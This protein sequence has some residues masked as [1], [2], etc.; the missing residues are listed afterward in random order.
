MRKLILQIQISVDGYIADENGNVDWLIWPWT[1]E[2]T[3]DP[4][5]RQYFYDLKDSIDTVL[6]SRKMAQEGF[7]NHWSQ[8]A[9]K[10]SNPQSVFAK[11][12]SEAKKIVF[13]RTLKKSEWDNAVLA[14]EDF[15]KEINTLKAQQG[16]DIIVYGGATFV[17]SLIDANLIDEFYLF[18]NPTSLG[19]GLSIFKDR[20]KLNL[21]EARSFECGV[22]V[23]KYLNQL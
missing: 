3:W 20:H 8:V 19:K 14:K 13:S 6:L 22:A 16:K 4:K 10:S 18:I 12:I 11:K 23:L 7:I 15:I 21:V 1:E 5:L 17:S 9:N 2:W